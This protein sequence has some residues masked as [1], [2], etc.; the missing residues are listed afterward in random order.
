MEMTNFN[1]NDIF[2]GAFGNVAPGMCRLTMNGLI[3]IKTPS[4]YKAYN[5]K[6]KNLVNCAMFVV[7]IADDMFMVMPT[8]KLKEGDITLINN[9]PV[10]VLDA[11]NPE[12]IEALA[13]ED[14]TIKTIVPER[15]LLMGKKFYGKI[16]S[17]L[18]NM[19][20]G[21][22]GGNI[23]SKMFK[24]KMMSNMFG[25]NASSSASNNFMM[26]AM[27]GGLGNNLTN[28]FNFDGEDS[29]DTDMFSNMFD[30]S[31]DENQ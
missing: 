7:D 2:G 27:M 23:W 16:V 1:M 18:G 17:M 26:M 28:M 13:Y 30:N 19:T 10:Y 12:R 3:G 29:I 22:G 8:T 11:S 4:G 24:L 20:G 31:S 5:P 15:H 6:T 14:S 21:L 25:S 9:K